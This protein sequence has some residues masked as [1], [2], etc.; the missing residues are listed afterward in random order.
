MKCDIDGVAKNIKAA[1]SGPDQDQWRFMVDELA[2]NLKER[3]A[4]IER[5]QALILRNCDPIDATP[6]DCKTIMEIIRAAEAAKES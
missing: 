6:E 4:E 2:R 1:I 5:L 3:E